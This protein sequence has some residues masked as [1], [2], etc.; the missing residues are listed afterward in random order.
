MELDSIEEFEKNILIASNW[1]LNLT[2]TMEIMIIIFQFL[3][4]SFD[5]NKISDSN[6]NSL[7]IHLYQVSMIYFRAAVNDFDIYSQF[8]EHI[9]LLSSIFINLNEKGE[10]KALGKLLRENSGEIDEIQ[11]CVNLIE[12]LVKNMFDENE[13]ENS[14]ENFTNEN[15]IGNSFAKFFETENVNYSTKL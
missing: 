4:K 10:N 9:I 1:R 15:V 5:I 6:T 7:S 3:Y 8:P 13:T 12:N 2:S 14:E 11:Q